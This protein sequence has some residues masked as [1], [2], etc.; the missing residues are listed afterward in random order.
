MVV[1]GCGSGEKDICVLDCEP[2]SRW[3]PKDLNEGLLVQDSVVRSQG[4]EGPFGLSL[5]LLKLK[6]EN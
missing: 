2:L 6:T 3:E 1:S 5:L 4:T